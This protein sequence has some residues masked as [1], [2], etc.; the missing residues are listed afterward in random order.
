[1]L[2]FVTTLA[3]GTFLPANFRTLLSLIC[4]IRY[5]VFVCLAYRVQ[6]PTSAALKGGNGGFRSVLL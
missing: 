6:T 5:F 3:M 4:F 1:M 2:C